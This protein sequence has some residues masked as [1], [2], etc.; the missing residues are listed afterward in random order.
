MIKKQRKMR[1]NTLASTFYAG[2]AGPTSV[3]FGLRA[4]AFLTCYSPVADPG[5]GRGH[6]RR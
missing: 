2:L 3:A 1:G 5:G 6:T 4:S